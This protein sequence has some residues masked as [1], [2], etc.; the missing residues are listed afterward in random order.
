MPA[1]VRPYGGI[2]IASRV[3]SRIGSLVIPQFEI[4]CHGNIVVATYNALM[5]A[6]IIQTVGPYRALIKTGAL[7][8]CRH[9]SEIFLRTHDRHAERGA[10]TLVSNQLKRKG[11]FR[12][13]RKFEESIAG[14]LHG[15]PETCFICEEAY[16]REDS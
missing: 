8:A 16:E 15:A 6:R 5:A 10:Y 12:F 4:W 1:E 9:H 14:I 13:V 2:T 3:C 7:R 11:D